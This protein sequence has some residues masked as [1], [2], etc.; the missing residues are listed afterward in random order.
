MG[1][2]PVV[3]EMFGGDTYKRQTIRED[4]FVVHTDRYV[5]S[6]I[7]DDSISTS[8]C[9]ACGIVVSSEDGCYDESEIPSLELHARGLCAHDP[10]TDALFPRM[11]AGWV[12]VL[13]RACRTELVPNEN[14]D[15]PR[16]VREFS[17]P[18]PLTPEE[19]AALA[20]EFF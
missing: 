8:K 17:F 5:A 12:S 18:Q 10:A 19:L 11:I 3:V 15:E 13:G 20:A 16:W 1:A 2:E 14:D 7:F 9:R 4:G 6:G